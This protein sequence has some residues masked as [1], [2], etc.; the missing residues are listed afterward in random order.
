MFWLENVQVIKRK[1]RNSVL[2]KKKEGAKTF[3][4]C[5]MYHRWGGE[6]VGRISP[7]QICNKCLVVTLITACQVTYTTWARFKGFSGT[8]KN[9]GL[10][11]SRFEAQP[12]DLLRAFDNF[13]A[14]DFWRRGKIYSYAFFFKDFGCFLLRNVQLNSIC[15]V[16][17]NWLNLARL[18]HDVYSFIWCWLLWKPEACPFQKHSWQSW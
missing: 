9:M 4:Q 7:Q 16:W 11:G 12:R 5:W 6:K 3:A 15:A 18:T 1:S 13:F 17:K 8:S 10:A 2:K 14:G